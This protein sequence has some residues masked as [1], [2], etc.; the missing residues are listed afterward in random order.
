M[1]K[2][3][4]EL[5]NGFEYSSNL[6]FMQSLVPSL[7]YQLLFIT[8]FTSALFAE[9]DKVFG[10]DAMAIGALI[11]V[12]LLELASGTYAS[13]IKKIPF[14]SRR[15]SRFTF[16]MACYLVLISVPYLFEVS[17][18]KHDNDLAAGLFAWLH[19]FLVVQIVVENIV[20]ILENLAQIQGKDKTYWIDK[21][22]SK[23]TNSL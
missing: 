19:V 20:S 16:K 11:V 8:M 5:L 9:V 1:K 22:K 23:I 6:E 14:S 2:A 13:R 21:I 15:L 12:M 17:F 18:K 7:K 3:V 10:L 4:S